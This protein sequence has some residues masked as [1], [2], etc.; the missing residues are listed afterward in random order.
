MPAV[1]P[2]EAPLAV[3]Q[4]RFPEDVSQAGTPHTPLRTRRRRPPVAMLALRCASTL[5]L[6]DAVRECQPEA[7][8]QRLKLVA[9]SDGRGPLQPNTAAIWMRS[10]AKVNGSRPG[11]TV[12]GRQTCAG[13]PAWQAHQCRGWLR[14]IERQLRAVQSSAAECK[15][16]TRRLAAVQSPCFSG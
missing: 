6:S 11:N 2:P 3:V 10:S 5:A 16:R 15:G 8:S 9:A 1:Q 7:M 13:R 12:A 14:S 4:Q